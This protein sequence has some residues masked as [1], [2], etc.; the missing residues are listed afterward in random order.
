M[1]ICFI[2]MSSN[3]G[4]KVSTINEAVQEQHLL[5]KR[6]VPFGVDLIAIYIH[7]SYV[8]HQRMG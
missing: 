8:T 4:R 2:I 3:P 6:I 1:Q 5:Y 7:K